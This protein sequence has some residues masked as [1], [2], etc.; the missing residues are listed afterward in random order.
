MN[1]VFMIGNLS[2]D[3]DLRTTQSGKAV[4]TLTIAVNRR[5]KGQDGEK[6]T[7]FFTVV[8]WNQLGEMCGKYL[9]KGKKVAVSGELQTRSYGAKD[10]SKRYVTEIIADEVEFLSPR[11]APQESVQETQGGFVDIEDDHLPF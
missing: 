11:E 2:K 9:A 1:K 6:V 10:G 7:D 8:A 3:V 5:F 4:A